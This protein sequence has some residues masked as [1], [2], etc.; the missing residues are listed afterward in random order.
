MELSC[1]YTR[2]SRPW[3]SWA[4]SD[5]PCPA[6]MRSRE[7]FPRDAAMW[8]AMR[9]S[10]ERASTSAPPASSFSA[11]SNPVS[12]ASSALR[13]AA[14]AWRGVCPS[15]STIVAGTPAST[16]SRATVLCPAQSAF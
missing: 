6:S 5:A 14:S 2:G 9:P 8:V 1:A 13:P 12:S 4:C 10:E 11:T 3:R 7:H 16:K 15:M